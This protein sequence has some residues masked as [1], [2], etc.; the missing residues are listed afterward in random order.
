MSAATLRI[1]DETAGGDLLNEVAIP[2]DRENLT[3]KEIIA[4]RVEAEVEAYVEGRLEAAGADAALRARFDAAAV[5]ALA[6][7]SEGVPIVVMAWILS[8]RELQP[9]ISW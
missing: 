2:F 7:G 4:A 9:I 8:R 5:E 1:V 3:V 6:R